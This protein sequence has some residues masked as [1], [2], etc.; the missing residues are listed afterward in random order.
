M[1]IC[2]IEQMRELDSLATKQ[3]GVSEYLL[4]ENAGL[5][6]IQLIKQTNP[7]YRK[8]RYL[9]VCGPGNNGGD[10]FVIAR[11]LKR[12][13]VFVRV[14]VLGN[15]HHYRA[16]AADNWDSIQ[17]L[18]IPVEVL[19][20]INV[21][22][23]IL[24]ESDQ[25]I[26]GI[27][28]TGISRNV[29]GLFSE[30]ITAINTSGKPVISLDIP[31]GVN[32][33]TGMIQGNAIKAQQTVTFGLPKLGNLL[34][35]GFTLSGDLY[36]STISFPSEMIEQFKADYIINEAAA[37]PV[38]DPSGYKGHF[39]E[40]LV[41]GGASGYFGAPYF[42]AIS[43]LRSGGG[44]VRLAAPKSIIPQIATMGPEIVFHPME[45]T[46]EGS[47]A[48]SNFESLIDLS[49]RV[50]VIII[51]PGLSLQPETQELSRKLVSALEKP[52]IIDGDGLTSIAENKQLLAQRVFPTLL[53]PHVGELSRL[54][55]MT[56]EEITENRP[57]AVKQARET[58][59]SDL[60]L[61]GAHTLIAEKGKS[62]HLNI[63]GNSGMGTAGS[64][65]LLT[66]VV[67]ACLTLGLNWGEAVRTGVFL[68]GMAGDLATER[69]GEDGVIASSILEFIPKA[70]N[71][72][73][74][75]AEISDSLKSKYRIPSIA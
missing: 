49:E 3:Y 53:T 67:A 37:L 61:K 30:V 33:N 56:S 5:S 63:S 31:S 72:H 43:F 44:Y 26:D 74:G 64:G 66:G 11:H 25:L 75:N 35:P 27:L 9:I 36:H 12:L 16:A 20:S 48:T 4:M 70:F 15:P 50:D 57:E 24:S 2:T 40:M 14:V 1:K 13:G 18:G 68:H 69:I 51:G 23:H 42:S 58:L 7:N 55:N 46:V 62:V 65:D 17:D 38:R 8:I 39:G 47:L 41:I 10:G 32:G 6:V 52:L 34:F 29:G 19:R 59:N 54:I 60:I 73:R 28:G 45:E 22:S 21:F 71:C